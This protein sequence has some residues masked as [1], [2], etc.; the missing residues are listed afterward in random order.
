MRLVST[1]ERYGY[2]K[3]MKQ[4]GYTFLE[5]QIR[6]RFKDVSE[7]ALTRIKMADSSLHLQWASNLMSAEKLEDV[8]RD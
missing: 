8:F 2:E 7:E 5:M 6:I 3:G 1:A 4:C